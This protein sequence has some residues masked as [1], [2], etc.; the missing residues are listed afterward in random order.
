V[1]LADDDLETRKTAL[2]AAASASVNAESADAGLFVARYFEH[3]AADDI[4]HWTPDQIR[5]VACD[6]LEFATI[7]PAGVPK[8]RV[9]RSA[10][11]PSSA[12][13]EVVTD[14]MPFLVDSVTQELA[15]HDVA[16]HLLVHP[17]LVVRRDLNGKLHEVLGAL[18]AHE[19][20]ADALVESW[21]HIE[22]AARADA[23]AEEALG[24]DVVRVLRDV[25]DA[26]EDWRRMQTI[27]A[28]TAADLVAHRP[29]GVSRVETSDVVE[30][31]QWLADNHFTFLGYREYRLVDDDGV[32]ALE[33]VPGTG[34]GILRGDKPRPRP[35]TE[36][37]PEV[38]ARIHDKQLLLITKANSRST[39]HRPVYLD[40]VGV[41][42]FDAAGNVTGERRFLGLFTSTA[43][44]QS[45]W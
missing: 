14:D 45:V 39:V 1:S 15:R 41:K 9:F 27:A 13:I 33:V 8:V 31:L 2:L 19:A 44:T 26:V 5:D 24:R 35:L 16:I 40:Y 25:R 38:R 22:V 12:V 4:A 37:P 43:Y 18:D 42:L 6:Q 10:Q 17:Q 36:L 3:V 30:F 23:D 20:P 34:L 32:E 11:R 7:R 21:M 29:V 28:R